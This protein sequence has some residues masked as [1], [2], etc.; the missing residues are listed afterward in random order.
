MWSEIGSKN[1][2]AVTVTEQFKHPDKYKLSAGQ[3]FESCKE[4]STYTNKSNKTI[5]TW[6]NKGWIQ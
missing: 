1:T 5:Y 6:K 4:L 3:H 2:K